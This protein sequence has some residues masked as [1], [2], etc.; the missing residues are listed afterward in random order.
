MNAIQI[1]GLIAAFCTTVSFLPQAVKTIKTRDTASISTAMYS[2][3]TAGTLLWLLYG[4]YTKNTPIILA[5][6]VT[7]VMA[8]IILFYKLREKRKAKS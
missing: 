6:G 2:F 4:I 1:L 7:F 8:V 3:F 5:N